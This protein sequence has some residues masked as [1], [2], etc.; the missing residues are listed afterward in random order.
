MVYTFRI[1]LGAGI[2]DSSCIDNYNNIVFFSVPVTAPV[3][4]SESAELT[5]TTGTDVSPIIIII[6]LNA[7]CQN[8]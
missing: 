1:A 8:L 3:T 2:N 7:S 6:T 5:E 4:S